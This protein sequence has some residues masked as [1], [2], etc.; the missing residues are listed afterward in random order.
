[1]YQHTLGEVSA[2]LIC[3]SEEEPTAIYFL[4]PIFDYATN[5]TMGV[6]VQRRTVRTNG[7]FFVTE[8]LTNG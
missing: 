3:N 6:T 7:L 2:L 1:M 8:E 4:F 5:I